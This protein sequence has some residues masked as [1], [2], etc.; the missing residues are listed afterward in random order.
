MARAYRYEQGIQEKRFVSGTRILQAEEFRKI[1]K[2][3]ENRRNLQADFSVAVLKVDM[4]NLDY[5]GLDG[6]LSHVIRNEDFVGVGSNGVY[7]LLPDADEAV[8]AMVQERLQGAGVA[9]VVCKAVE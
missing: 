4:S 1:I 6:R 2:E 8:T 5:A 3:L 7:I 9:T